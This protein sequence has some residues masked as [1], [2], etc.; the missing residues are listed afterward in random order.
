M[1][2]TFC[3]KCYRG[4]PFTNV[5][6]VALSANRHLVVLTLRETCQ[7]KWLGSHLNGISTTCDI[8]NLLVVCQ[9]VDS[10][11]CFGN[12]GYFHLLR[13]DAIRQLGYL[14]ILDVAKLVVSSSDS[15]VFAFTCVFIQHLLS[16]IEY[17]WVTCRARRRLL[18]CELNS[19]QRFK[20]LCIPWIFY[21][22]Q[23]IRGWVQINRC[24][25]LYSELVEIYSQVRQDSHTL[26]RQ[27]QYWPY[28]SCFSRCFHLIR[29]VLD[30]RSSYT[31]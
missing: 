7:C 21:G 13:S 4:C 24:R 22:S 25:N 18:L 30:S 1:N 23:C 10:S 14:N 31:R 26:C 28:F 9:P 3:S 19:H 12:T 6:I 16:H 2:T 20:A 8:P 15:Q 11:R 5:C 17:V 27:F 29:A